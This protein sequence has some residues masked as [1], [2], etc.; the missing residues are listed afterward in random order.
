M[1]PQILN[2]DELKEPGSGFYIK[3]F[4]PSGPKIYP[5]LVFCPSSGKRTKILM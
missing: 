5:F 4:V 3:E 2:G 1:K